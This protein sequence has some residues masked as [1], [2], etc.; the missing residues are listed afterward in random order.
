MFKSPEVSL[1]LFVEFII[2]SQQ[3]SCTYTCIQMPE[4]DLYKVKHM[5]IMQICSSLIID[6]SDL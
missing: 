1:V 4:L 6:E 3:V 2:Y 5:H